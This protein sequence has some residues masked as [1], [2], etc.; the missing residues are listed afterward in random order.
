LQ[1]REEREK[2]TH[3]KRNNFLSTIKKIK[4]GNFFKEITLQQCNY[5]S[6]VRRHYARFAKE[7]RIEMQSSV[8]NFKIDGKAYVEEK[9]GGMLK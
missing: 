9:E 4:K 5:N 2:L 8:T 6:I 7:S 3:T 1:R